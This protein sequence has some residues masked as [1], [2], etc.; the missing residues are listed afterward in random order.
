MNVLFTRNRAEVWRA[1]NP[2]PAPAQLTAFPAADPRPLPPP[3]QT[4]LSP[5]LLKATL[6]LLGAVLLGLIGALL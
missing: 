5:G 1:T 3:A 6:T 4:H 2:T